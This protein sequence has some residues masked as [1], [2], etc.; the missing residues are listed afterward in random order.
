M[1]L[2]KNLWGVA[3]GGGNGGSKTASIYFPTGP[4]SSA[5]VG[6]FTAQADGDVVCT[7][8]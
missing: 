7:G 8:G 1:S 5:T 3:G 6:W 4:S 2:L